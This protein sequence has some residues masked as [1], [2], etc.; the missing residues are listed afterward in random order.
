MM[1]AHFLI[2]IDYFIK[3]LNQISEMHRQ[4]PAVAGSLARCVQIRAEI[5]MAEQYLLDL[6][7]ELEQSEQSVEISGADLP[8]DVWRHI[9][10]HLFRFSGNIRNLRAANRG[11]YHMCNQLR[12]D[13]GPEIFANTPRP[14]GF[15]HI[16]TDNRET[17]KIRGDV[18]IINIRDCRYPGLY[19][20]HFG[21]RRNN[22]VCIKIEGTWDDYELLK[23][24][25][26]ILQTYVGRVA[27]WFVKGD[28]EYVSLLHGARIYPDLIC[29]EEIILGGARPLPIYKTDMVHTITILQG[30]SGFSA[31]SYQSIKK[32][33]IAAHSTSGIICDDF[34]SS[35]N[36]AVLNCRPMIMS[37][38][39]YFNAGSPNNFKFILEETGAQISRSGEQ[40]NIVPSNL[41]SRSMDV[42]WRKI[43][44]RH[45]DIYQTL[46]YIG[47]NN[48]EFED[49]EN[50]R[51]AT[52]RRLL[53][54]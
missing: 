40:Y 17:Y 22:N 31:T 52:E 51:Q 25:H 16:V 35:R 19:V 28:T 44:S 5:A 49:G 26:S 8:M 14:P 2:T 50:E 33:N 20:N 12:T 23:R 3:Y 24:C 11:L 6:R 9:A 39:S 30:V 29:A 41:A 43:M 32:L 34:H 10:Y 46:I 54:K 27:L 21:D 4:Y 1:Y 45:G 15:T 42:M 13:L 47:I 7:A 53:D 37:R 48:P 18:H 38:A 36:R